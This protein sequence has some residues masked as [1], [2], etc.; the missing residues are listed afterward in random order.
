MPRQSS[1]VVRLQLQRC[2]QITDGVGRCAGTRPVTSALRSRGCCVI[3]RR[4]RLCHEGFIDCDQ[5]TSAADAAVTGFRGCGAFSRGKQM[6]LDGIGKVDLFV[7]LL[8][9]GAVEQD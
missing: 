3:G 7:E 9:A 8:R 5:P 6:R 2:W 1:G 4:N